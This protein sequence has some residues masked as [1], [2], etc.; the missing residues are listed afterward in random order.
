MLDAAALRELLQKKMVGPAAK[1]ASVAH[2]QAIMGLS[3]RRACRIVDADRTMISTGQAGR[4]IRR[5][6]RNCAIC[7]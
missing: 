3:E 6:G 5:C 4:P 7:Q 1:R 2:L